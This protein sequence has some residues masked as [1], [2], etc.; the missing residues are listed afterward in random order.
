MFLF[1]VYFNKENIY[2]LITLIIMYFICLQNQI[3]NQ[4]AIKTHNKSGDYLPQSP[5]LFDALYLF[6]F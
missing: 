6:L 5:L 2:L 3:M 1:T 4:T